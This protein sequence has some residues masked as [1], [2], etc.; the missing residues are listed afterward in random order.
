MAHY[1]VRARLKLE[2][3]RELERRLRRGDFEKLRPF[4]KALTESLRGAR[5]DEPKQ[6]A[7]WEEEDYC[8]PPL[9]EERRAV[10]DHYF[11]GIEVES[12]REGEGWN[13]ISAL[14]LLWQLEEQP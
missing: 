1:L 5:W 12:V 2:L 11:A 6:T 4:G 3:R 14:P 10:L 9:A 7:V 13:R 8:S